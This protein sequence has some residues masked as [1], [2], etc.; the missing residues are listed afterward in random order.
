MSSPEV[1]VV[2]CTYNRCTDLPFALDGVLAQRDAPSYEVI[3]VDNDSTD[4]TAAVVDA[5]RAAHPRLRYVFEPG[6]GL[7]RARNAGIM[8]A[9]AP[10]IAFTDDDVVVADNWVGSVYQAFLQYPNA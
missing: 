4:A 9:G 1:S 2:I 5:R 8:N 7:P 10:I 6:P 3:V